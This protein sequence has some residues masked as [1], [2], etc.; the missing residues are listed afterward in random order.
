MPA[1]RPHEFHMGREKN[2]GGGQREHSAM[3]DSARP[4]AHPALAEIVARICAIPALF[5]ALGNVSV[6]EL[7]ER[8]GYRVAAA[9]LT[10]DAISSY[11]RERP[12]LIE[13]WLGYS[14]DKRTSSGWYIRQLSRDA[15]EIGWYPQGER[16]VVSGKAEACAEF[17]IREI[18]SIAR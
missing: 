10:V 6:A 13:A 3:A 5:K 8:S 16:I 11:L 17:I 18:R 4:D 7:V 2:Q 9:E 14:E 1:S 15:F 12:D